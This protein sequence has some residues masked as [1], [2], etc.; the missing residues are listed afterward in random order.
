MINGGDDSEKYIRGIMIYYSIVLSIE[1][2]PIGTGAAS[3]GSVMSKGSQ[4]YINL[5]IDKLRF[6]RDMSGVYDCNIATILGEFGIVG[7][8]LFGLLFWKLWS[9]LK[10]NNSNNNM[11]YYKVLIILIFFI[12]LKGSM[13]MHSYTSLI[14]A[15]ALNIKILPERKK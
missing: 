2:F 5:D 9:F 1:Y 12:M 15:M 8:I 4:V 11:N 10:K 6:F 14:F 3:Y 13:L 7:I